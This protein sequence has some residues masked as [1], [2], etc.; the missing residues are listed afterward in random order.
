MKKDILV[1]TAVFAALAFLYQQAHALQEFLAVSLQHLRAYDFYGLRDY[2]LSFGARAPLASILLMVAQ[3][4]IPFV[5]GIVMTIANA[6][7]FGWLLGGVYTGVGAALGA[8][9]DFSISRWYGKPFLQKILR[10]K[11]ARDMN[12]FVDEHGVIAVLITRLVPIIPY[13]AVSYSA[14]CSDMPVRAF[15]GATVLG[16][17]PAIFLYSYL[18]ERILD[19]GYA[20]LFAT[21]ILSVLAVAAYRYRAAFGEI[22]KRLVGARQS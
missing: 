4:V 15:I 9:L 18:G 22:M 1:K 13:K 20:A 3:S 5:P 12:R 19:N 10:G 11:F 16:Q 21:L 6:W 2:L 14:G 7:L 17:M 8:A